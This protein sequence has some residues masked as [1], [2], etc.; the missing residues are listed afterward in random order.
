MKVGN[1]FMTKILFIF[2]VPLLFCLVC[3]TRNSPSQSSEANGA[4][5]NIR[6]DS[7]EKKVRITAVGHKPDRSRDPVTDKL[8]ACQNARN[9]GI[10]LFHQKY[11]SGISP[12]VSDKKHLGD[13]FS[14][15]FHNSGIRIQTIKKTILENGDCEIVLQFTGKD[16]YSQDTFRVNTVKKNKSR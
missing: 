14:D 2:V 4:D 12:L 8:L 3:S 16:I 11:L 13:K 1:P 15:S 6:N 5:E 7:S 9:E 10:R